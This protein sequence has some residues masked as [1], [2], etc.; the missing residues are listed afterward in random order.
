ML[1]KGFVIGDP[2][3]QTG[4]FFLADVVLPGESN[5]RIS[6]RLVDEEAKLILELNWN[7]IRENPGG[8]IYESIPTGFR[9]L[10]PSNEAFLEVRTQS[11]PYGYLSYIRTRLHDESSTLRMETLGESIH[12]HG[13]AELSLNS[14]FVF[15]P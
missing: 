12:V 11:F 13:E 7:R 5:S 3:S 10:R 6:C 15:L 4:F 9:I 2:N 1:T 14:P 8:Y